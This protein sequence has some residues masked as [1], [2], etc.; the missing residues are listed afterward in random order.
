MGEEGQ[1]EK[2]R[3][4]LWVLQGVGAHLERGQVLTPMG[5]FEAGLDLCPWTLP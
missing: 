4:S 3:E 1:E 2:H 5:D